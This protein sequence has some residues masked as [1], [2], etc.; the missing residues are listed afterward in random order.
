MLFRRINGN[1]CESEYRICGKG[2]LAWPLLQITELGVVFEISKGVPVMNARDVMTEGVQCIPPTTSL[3]E[4]AKM[5]QSLDV[6]A[7][8]V[9]DNDRLIAFDLRP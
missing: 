9:C 4:A 3:Q 7:L 1:S 2:L 8:P 6:G 5:M